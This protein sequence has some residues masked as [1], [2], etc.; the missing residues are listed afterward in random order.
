M[1]KQRFLAFLLSVVMIISQISFAAFAEETDTTVSISEEQ[2]AYNE[3]DISEET[4]T[5]DETISGSAVLADTE[6]NLTQAVSGG[7]VAGTTKSAVSFS[8]DAAKEVTVTASSA[9]QGKWSS[10]EDTHA[11]FAHEMSKSSNF[12]LKADMTVNNHN[13]IDGK[14]SNQNQSAVG[15]AVLNGIGTSDTLV[16]YVGLTTYAAA[17]TDS[18][19]SFRASYRNNAAEGKDVSKRVWGDILGENALKL[20]STDNQ[21]PYTLEIRKSGD[22]YEMIYD[23]N[24]YVIDDRDNKIFTGQNVYPAFVAARNIKATFTNISLETP[25]KTISKIELTKAPDTNDFIVGSRP[26]FKSA[27]ALVTATYSDGTKGEI[28]DYYVLL[29][30]LN[31]LGEQ[32][33]LIYKDG[34]SVEYTVNLVKN[35]PSEI[36]I[37]SAPMKDTYYV[38]QHMKTNL[39]SVS[40]L[41]MDGTK[42]DLEEGEYELYID[43]KLITNETFI[44]KDMAGKNK[45]V[46]VKFTATENI[47][48]GDKYGS[49]NVDILDYELQGLAVAVRPSKSFYVGDKFDPAGMQVRANFLND[50]GVIVSDVLSEDEYTLD[51]SEFDSSK[52]GKY[53][54]L[55]TYNHSLEEGTNYGDK[56]QTK[57]NVDV[58]VKNIINFLL[59]DYPVTTYELV[60]GAE[61]SS[62][63]FNKA[64]MKAAYHCN[65]G[66][67][68]YLEEDKD[69]TID[70]SEFSVKE[71]SNDKD[72]YKSFINI[73]PKDSSVS[74]IKLPVTVREQPK[75][76]W[77]ATRFGATTSGSTNST[78]GSLSSVDNSGS[79]TLN[80]GKNT[81]GDASS[82]TGTSPGGK[83]A[84]DHDGLT[85][86]YTRVS[87]D[88]NFMLSADVTINS[89]LIKD[90][91]DVSRAGQEAWGLMARDAIPMTGASGGVVEK[92]SEAK[93]DGD[94]EPTPNTSG[95]DFFG[96]IV[97]C[98]GYSGTSY[99]T[100]PTAA[101]Y[102]KNRD[103]NRVNLVYRKGVQTYT[104]G[105]GS[106][107]A[108]SGAPLNDNM[109]QKGEKF[110]I[111]L[112][113]VKGGYKGYC[114][115]YQTGTTKS[116]TYF[117]N[118]DE[119]DNLLAQ[120]PDNIYVGFFTAR[121][122]NI[123]V[124]NVDFVISDSLTDCTFRGEN[125]LTT[126]TPAVTLESRNYTNSENY[127]V[128]LKANNK[129]GG[130]V[131]IKQ[132]GKVVYKNYFISKKNVSFPVK[133]A[134]GTT[135]DFVVTYKPR[136]VNELDNNYEPLSSY[137]DVV[138]KFDVT[139]RDFDTEA[140]RVFYVSPDGSQHGDGTVE[141]PYDLDTGFGLMEMGQT[142]IL[143]EGVY[144][145]TEDINTGIMRD[146][147]EKYPYTI[148][149]EEG[150]EVVIDLQGIVGGMT[151]GSD[152]WTVENIHFRHS[153]NNQRAFQLGGNYC[154]VIN[155]KFY[156]NG[157]TG[158]QLSRVDGS[159]NAINVWPHGNLIKYCEVWNSADPSGINADGFGAKLTVGNGNKFYGC[160]SHHNL[161]DGWDLY[162]KGGTGPIGVITLE[163]CISYRQGFKLNEDGTEGGIMSSTAGHNGYKV[164]GEK[165]PVSHV[166]KNCK[167]FGNNS[168]GITSNSNPRMVIRNAVSWNNK[169]ANFSLT[170]GYKEG[171]D[172]DVKGIVS[173][174]PG[175]SDSIGSHAVLDEKG[176]KVYKLDENGNKIYDLYK[177]ALYELESYK[178]VPYN[179]V[180]GK[181]SLDETITED[182]FKTLN[183]EQYMDRYH[184][185]QSD[186]PDADGDV[187]A[188]ITGDFLELTDE[189]KAYIESQPGYDDPEP[190]DNESTETTTKDV[191]SD[192]D[193][194]PVR[195]SGGGSSS[196]SSKDNSQSNKKEDNKKDDNE[197]E[198]SKTD[199]K[200]TENTPVKVEKEKEKDVKVTA[201][202]LKKADNKITVDY[203][204]SNVAN[205]SI[206]KT[207][208]DVKITAGNV[209]VSITNG[210]AA[211]G[212]NVQIKKSEVLSEAV[213][214]KAL[215]NAVE[216]NITDAEGNTVKLD[217]YIWVSIDYSKEVTAP[218]KVVAAYV[219]KNDSMK[220]I[221]ASYYDKATKK[222]MF[223]IR[224]SGIFAAYEST[225]SFDDVSDHWAKVYIETMAAR[226]IING[227][228]NN[229]FAPNQNIKKGDFIKILVEML[230][231]KA[232][233]NSSYSDVSSSDYYSA[234][235]A[236]AK[237]Y[238]ILAAFNGDALGAKDNAT[239][240]E[241]MVMIAATMK[242]MNKSGQKADLSKFSDSDQISDYAKDSVAELVGMGIIEGSDG[243]LNPKSELTR[244]EA[245]KLIYSVWKE[246]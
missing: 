50:D 81:T 102:T 8:G 142:M 84:T 232:S 58:I 13:S 203:G 75:H 119:G 90:F 101:S 235:I 166:L 214:S 9:N 210:I 88:Q 3:T 35:S 141:N 27:G 71:V 237:E 167:A 127:N 227:I 244:A 89:Y 124:E 52:A 106:E 243:K 206:P 169:G 18:H 16:N 93:L 185:L 39:L 47:N 230:E 220:A 79:V 96:N 205:V 225:V 31:A 233:S 1:K 154:K 44:T 105:T 189:L 130:Y 197:K 148:K 10:N 192:N 156:D 7:W 164:G 26:D 208:D 196:S 136:Y 246:Y 207:E 62:K 226:D 43:N 76:K 41:F 19:A 152:Y 40:A 69:Y 46:K 94:G 202:E 108:I 133:I 91:N 240:E 4:D 223:P 212:M 121:F 239:R 177:V 72:G 150:K 34:V 163:N 149:G 126:V 17:K 172:F 87:G 222:V 238:G 128:V 77:Q 129:S 111:T 48:Q 180:N 145:R 38:G 67:Y 162:T 176:N 49:F 159:Q 73:V 204:D 120:D 95:G 231:L 125:A 171:Q 80:A 193:R 112:Q 219:N 209:G 173:Y 66:E 217:K 139:C 99:P 187:G 68:I 140:G 114:Y 55:V 183:Y 155:C 138:L 234:Q 194:G 188:F 25:D 213:Q 229:L 160:V 245:T 14:D 178:P 28:D 218:E 83:L 33:A 200:K 147:V 30:D 11:F 115:D 74:T 22:V 97:L 134:E 82:T 174:K 242:L 23:G 241:V 110:R 181:N 51:S 184:F 42:K 12:V 228:G 195:G 113:K 64:N 146:G 104:A 45:E 53:S 61:D 100:D 211:N 56:A 135:S 153:A 86:Y 117:W 29:D 57:F 15:M 70:L 157:D 199:D 65:N 103:I 60:P 32:K 186:K 144:Y 63:Y 168:S 215:D 131:D 158:F 190:E 37:N 54:I 21:G 107:R 116:S 236:A 118:S 5:T 6:I 165:V 191:V 224:E 216:I 198:D 36:I 137:D 2:T 161:D 179:Y 109:F 98:G 201:D 221:V 151:V 92:A 182:S 78:E 122:A 132:D 24:S 123:T 175:G 85:F 20:V 59:T 143:L 170:S